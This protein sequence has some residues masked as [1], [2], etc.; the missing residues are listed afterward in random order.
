MVSSDG[1]EKKIIYSLQIKDKEGR[2]NDNVKNA[3]IF[4][5]NQTNVGK[6]NTF[7]LLWLN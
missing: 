5:K 2:K 3:L 6:W 4:L 1:K 7:I